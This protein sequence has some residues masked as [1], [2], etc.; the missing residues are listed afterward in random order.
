[1]PLRDA[2]SNERHAESTILD[3]A[4]LDLI[5]RRLTPMSRPFGAAQM[6][7]VALL[8]FAAFLLTSFRLGWTR[9]A[10]DFPNYYTAAA[11]VRNGLPLHDYYNWTWFQRQ[12][13]LAGFGL[14]RGAYTPNTP[15][16]MLPMVGLAGFPPQT[17]KRIWLL[18]SLGMLAA[19]V[20]LL[21]RVSRFSIEQVALLAFCGIGSLHTNFLFGQYY[22]FLLFL[23]TF[24]WYCLYRNHAYSSGLFCGVAFGL[25]LYGGPFVLYFAARRKWKAVAGMVAVSVFLAAAAVALFGWADVVYYG[26]GIL[27]RTLE[28]SSVDPYNPNNATLVTL[29]RRLFVVD[30]GLNPNPLWNAPWLFFFLRAAVALA[31]V[32]FTVLGLSFSRRAS[33]R[34]A[35]AW[36][37]IAVLLLSTSTASYH[38]IVLLLLLVLLLEDAGR[39][40]SVFLIACYILLTLRLRPTWLFPKLWLL[41]ILFVYL[42]WAWWRA[43]PRKAV[44]WAALAIALAA[45]LD[46]GRHMSS[47]RNEPGQRFSRFAVENG[48]LFSGFPAVTRYGVFYQAMGRDRYVLHWLH[49]NRTEELLFDGH[50]LRPVAPVPGGVVWFE[51]LAHGTSTM[52]RFDPATRT[53][54]PGEPPAGTD[55]AEPAIAPNGKWAAFTAA[56]V[57][58]PQRIWL[59]NLTTNEARPL[60]AGNCNSWAPAWELDSRALLF[61]SD[62]GRAFG[63][64]ALYRASVP[65]LR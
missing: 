49:D 34:R 35:F 9:P 51:L 60:T 19:A 29:F 43:L 30:P 31:I 14:Q 42:G 11:A 63:L 61:A 52:M 26:T 50:A 32:A 15:L 25:K 10:T 64:P 7:T 62:C 6:R 5:S 16:T 28:G 46:A 41:L 36:F 58:G 33:E 3:G 39:W 1:M 54:T 20:W 40:E 55:A 23:L 17:A 2:I 27:P 56:T 24:A 38:F 59:R 48:Q 53:A 4:V 45:F 22:V 8:A 44:V 18:L 57:P 47:Y 13:S 21:S 37:M 65:A 12:M